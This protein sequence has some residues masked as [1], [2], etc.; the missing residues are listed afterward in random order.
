MEEV[1]EVAAIE[2]GYDRLKAEQMQVISKFV[3]GND[4]FAM[5]PTGFGKSLCYLCLPIVFDMLQDNFRQE[6][7]SIIVIVTPLTALIKDQA[8]THIGPIILYRLLAC[9]MPFPQ[10][11]Q[12]TLAAM[13]D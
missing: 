6:D 13:P 10:P 2:I 9:T 4:V 12:T 1:I 8:L 7:L 5:L 11:K 3:E